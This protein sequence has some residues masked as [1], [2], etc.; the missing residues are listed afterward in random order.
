MRHPILISPQ[1]WHW[2]SPKMQ[3]LGTNSA[4][5]WAPEKARWWPPILIVS[6]RWGLSRIQWLRRNSA[7]FWAPEK[8]GVK[9]PIMIISPPLGVGDPEIP[10]LCS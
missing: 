1:I 9:Q 8:V 2:E 7:L 3:R 10:G 4:L 6:P 5:F